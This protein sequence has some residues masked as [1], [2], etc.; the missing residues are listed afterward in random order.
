MLSGMRCSLIDDGTQVTNI[1]EFEDTTYPGG[2]LL[3]AEY[4]LIDHF[5]PGYAHIEA[6]VSLL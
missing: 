4:D 1:E 5:S 3:E 6:L 2:V